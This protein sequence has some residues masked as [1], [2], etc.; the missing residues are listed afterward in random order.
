MLA[1]FLDLTTDA[2]GSPFLNDPTAAP[3]EILSFKAMFGD[4]PDVPEH[5]MLAFAATNDLDTFY[6]RE[7]QSEPDFKDFAEAMVKEIM[8]QWDNANFRL[9][10]RS[11]LKKE[12]QFFMVCGL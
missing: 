4:E 7:A 3:G 9:R 2:L 11:E 10:R 6:L 1:A 12:H 8:N 5:P